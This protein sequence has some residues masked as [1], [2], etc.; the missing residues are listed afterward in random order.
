[1]ATFVGIFSRRQQTPIPFLPLIHT[2]T[3]PEIN[4]NTTCS[5]TSLID[6][7]HER[8]SWKTLSEKFGSLKFTNQIVQNILL[9]LR[10]PINS[11][12]ALNFFHWS[13]KEMNFE[14]GI[15]TYSLTIHIL[16][17]AR[18]IKDAKALIESVLI[19]DFSDGDSRML[20]VLESL[21]DSYEIVESVP[22]VFDLFIQTCAKLRMVDDILDACKLLSRQDFPLSVISFNTMLHVMIKSDKSRLVWSVYE[23]MISERMCP[24][25]MTTRIMVSAL[26]K[27]GK[28]ERFLGIVDRMH[29]KR[30][31][32][33]RLIVNTCLVYEMIEEDK[34]EEGLVLLKR[35][36]QKAMILDTISYSLVIFAKVKMGNL[37]NAKEIYEE[38]LK[39]GFEENAFVCSLF[40]GAYCEEGRIDEAVGLFEEMESLGLKPFD[41]T[42][43][44]LIKGCS[45]SYGRFEDGVVFC[46][47]MT[48]M[49]LVP[50]C[51]SVN[52]MFGKLCENAKTKEADEIL[53]ILLDKG[54]VA[55]GNT[56][57]HLVCGYGKEDDVEGLTKLLFEMEYRSIF[58]NVLGFTSVIVSFCNHGRLKDAEK[59]LGLMKSQS[60]IPS[61]NVYERLIAGHLQ[62][63]NETRA[64]QLYGEMV[65]IG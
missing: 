12:K 28:L 63:G 35:M 45:S 9:Q 25:E 2:L 64:R 4:G 49:G 16:V 37:D 43:N 20:D 56:Y 58:P 10:E 3:K 15:S 48:S 46:K 33:P 57:S 41:E 13:R 50:R 61:S 51:S 39:R 14:H 7:L 60:F 31:S 52:E 62:N 44:H 17:K 27:E 55:D 30:C 8:S 26:C 54:F 36:L 24:N 53:T 5:I 47:K 42:F 38:M 22:F 34:I 1:M 65:G 59:Y 18:L 19:K 32:I 11:R 21:I 29:G 23:H 6:S 40:I